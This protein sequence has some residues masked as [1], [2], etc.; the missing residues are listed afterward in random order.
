MKRL[1]RVKEGSI[2]GGVCNGLGEYFNIDPIFFRITFVL[3][4]FY[5]FLSIIVYILLLVL[6]PKK[7]IM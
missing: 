5:F 6:L 1:F 4:S 7:L 3:T 2:I